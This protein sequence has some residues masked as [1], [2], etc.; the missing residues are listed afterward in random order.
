M[1]EI[2]YIHAQTFTPIIGPMLLSA[3]GL[4]GGPARFAVVEILDKIRR[5]DNGSQLTEPSE[6]HSAFDRF[7]RQSVRSEMLHEVVIGMG[8]LDALD[9]HSLVGMSPENSH[10]GHR[11]SNG[12]HSITNV[13]DPDHF[14]AEAQIDAE[15]Q[16]AV[17]RLASMSLIASVAASGRLKSTCSSFSVTSHHLRPN[18]TRHYEYIY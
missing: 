18:R 13:D 2:A 16:A 5:I 14:D 8:R 15:R 1:P 10:D 11:D 17:G 12:Q 7:S 3:N 4:I 9:A 6:D